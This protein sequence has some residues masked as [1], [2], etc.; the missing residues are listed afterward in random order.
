MI[1]VQ[2]LEGNDVFEMARLFQKMYENALDDY[3]EVLP[4]EISNFETIREKNVDSF[5]EFVVLFN[6]IVG[7]S[8]EITYTEGLI[9]PGD[10]RDGV[11]SAKRLIKDLDPLIRG[12]DEASKILGETSRLLQGKDY[13]NDWKK[14]FKQTIVDRIKAWIDNN[15]R[16]SR[17]QKYQK[18]V[19]ELE[20]V[21]MLQIGG[22]DDFVRSDLN[23]DSKL[24]SSLT[25]LNAA[26][27]EANEQMKKQFVAWNTSV[28]S[29][30]I[31]LKREEVDLELVEIQS[32]LT[33]ITKSA[34][35]G[36]T[37]KNFDILEKYM[38]NLGSPNPVN[39]PATKIPGQIVN[40]RTD[41]SDSDGDSEGDSDDDSDDDS[42]EGGE[43]GGDDFGVD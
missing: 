20:Y 38:K 33:Q 26:I 7:Y 3:T 10:F 23:K 28:L 6:K 14:G 29:G 16:A 31:F 15:K 27:I 35:K 18:V 30:E 12:A 21:K 9:P 41:G 39:V 32:N 8:D 25:K 36:K 22:P 34:L 42:E 40:P 19:D 2:D 13:D 37:Q 24:Y 4:A 17:N 11:S 5:K 43:E 1:S